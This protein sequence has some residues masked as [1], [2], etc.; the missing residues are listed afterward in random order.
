MFTNEKD[1]VV[2]NDDKVYDV[3][4]KELLEGDIV[5]ALDVIE[6]RTQ[7]IHGGRCFKV[8]YC[9]GQQFAIDEVY[10]DTVEGII[11]VDEE[12]ISAEEVRFV[13]R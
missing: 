2:E 4:G 9:K 6:S 10:M 11:I 7:L 1:D 5:E 12:E 3:N 13:S 8:L